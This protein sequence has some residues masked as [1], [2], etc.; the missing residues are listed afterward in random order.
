MDIPI[1]DFLSKHLGKKTDSA[2]A[3]GSLHAK[4]ADVKT[5][6]T[7]LQNLVNSGVL[8]RQCIASNTLRASADTYESTGSSETPGWVRMKSITVDVTG[9]IRVSYYASSDTNTTKTN[10]Y[11][12]GSP[13]GTERTDLTT[14]ATYTEDLF[15]VA[16]DSIELWAYDSSSSYS[17]N[18]QNFRIYFDIVT[19]A[20]YAFVVNA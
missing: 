1:F 5:A 20:N 8:H 10:I 15:F 2:D 11:R 19:T 9:F 18:V 3:A 12:N 4:V 17:V 13:W 7:S 14:G 16:G 6:T